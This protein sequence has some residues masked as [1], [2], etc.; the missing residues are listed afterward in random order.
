MRTMDGQVLKCILYSWFM[1]VWM[2]DVCLAQ[3]KKQPPLPI[4][5][6][7]YISLRRCAFVHF[8]NVVIVKKKPLLFAKKLLMLK[9]Q[10]YKMNAAR[11]WLVWL[12]TLSAVFLTRAC[13]WAC[14]Q[15]LWPRGWIP[16]ERAPSYHTPPAPAADGSGEGPSA[17]P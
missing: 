13:L 10:Q 6:E 8:K 12:S 1:A 16:Q 9:G 17:L 15:S 7:C 2:P 5:I 3:R 11:C 4:Q 14:E